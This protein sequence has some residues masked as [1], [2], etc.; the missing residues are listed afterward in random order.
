M[1][2]TKSKTDRIRTKFRVYRLKVWEKFPTKSKLRILKNFKKK[3]GLWKWFGKVVS[4]MINSS[5][6]K[7]DD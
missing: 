7:C 2:R 4:K 6:K 1:L 5:S 3:K